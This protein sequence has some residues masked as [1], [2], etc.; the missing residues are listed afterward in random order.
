M[1]LV[2]LMLFATLLGAVGATQAAER[3]N[4]PERGRCLVAPTPPVPPAPPAPPE[5]PMPP[6]PP[7]P[8]MPTIPQTAHDACAAMR[9]GATLSFVPH[10]GATMKGTCQK[11]SKGMYFD[12]N[13]YTSAD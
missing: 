8:P 2:S 5:P 11:D 12:L 7:E 10:K 4:C 3:G 13:V 1:K 9:I 6:V